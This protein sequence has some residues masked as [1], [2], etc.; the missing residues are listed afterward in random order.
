[1]KR[2]DVDILDRSAVFDG[3]FRIDRYRLRHKLFAGGWSGAMVRELFERGHAAALLPYDP[4]LDCVV[5][6]EQFRIG[7]YAAGRHPWLIEVVAG[8]I[9]GEDESA[10]DVVRREAEE[11]AGLK[12]GDVIQISE[13]LASPGGT[14]ETV[15]LFCGRVDASNAGG[16]YGLSAEHEDIRVFTVPVG[17]ISALLAEKRTHN[18]T[19]LIALQWLILHR[20]EIR[21]RWS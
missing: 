12:V 4:V 1:M 13:Y 16:L 11:E 8:I 3:Y 15:A 14:S 9:D 10:E 18:A 20:D 19:A 2:N 17:D 6:I 21:R 5:L 7:A